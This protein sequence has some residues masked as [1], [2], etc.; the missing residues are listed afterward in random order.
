[1]KEWI[2]KNKYSIFVILIFIIVMCLV[3][4]IYITN[5]PNELDQW[6]GLYNYVEFYPQNNGMNYYM[7]NEITIYRVGK[8]YYAIIVGDGWFLGTQSL[9]RVTGNKDKIDITFLK[10]LPRDQCYRFSKGKYTYGE[11][12]V[13]L[14]LSGGEL[15][16]EWGAL[17]REQESI[18]NEEKVVGKYFERIE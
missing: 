3:L 11:M 17:K 2:M 6:I 5:R 4:N 8:E 18:I 9:A 14:E 7:E 10:T 16:T 1:M 12:L 13:H 15:I